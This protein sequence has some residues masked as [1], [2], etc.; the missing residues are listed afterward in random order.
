MS[1]ILHAS[2]EAADEL[3]TQKPLIVPVSVDSYKKNSL[4]AFAI[5]RSPLSCVSTAPSSPCNEYLD[6]PF[7]DQI[8]FSRL[9]TSDSSQCSEDE[10]FDTQGSEPWLSL[11]NLDG[12]TRMILDGIEDKLSQAKAL[13]KSKWGEDVD[14]EQFESD[15]G[16]QWTKV[17]GNGLPTVEDLQ[18]SLEEAKAIYNKKHGEDI[19][20]EGSESEEDL[21]WVKVVGSGV[22]SVEE[23]Q[24]SLEEAKDMYKEKWGED[25][26]TDEWDSDENVQWTKVV[27]SGFLT[28]NTL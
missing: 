9:T 21:Q 2:A 1:T 3:Q 8:R 17:V 6:V 12:Q 10:E 15:E 13:Y 24:V 19:N 25:V 11:N 5:D 23:L 4:T 14:A 18:Q 7:G 22:P 28:E 27:G 26:N 16:V 20:A